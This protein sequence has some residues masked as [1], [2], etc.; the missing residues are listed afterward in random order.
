MD[1][2]QY[3]I[4]SLPPQMQHKVL[5]GIMTHRKDRSWSGTRAFL[6]FHLTRPAIVYVCYDRRLSQ[7]GTPLWLQYF[8]KT[9]WVLETTEATFD[10]RMKRY[11]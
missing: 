1:K 11:P 3:V 6:S 8:H 4:V 7:N 10:V 2:P 9:R 5:G